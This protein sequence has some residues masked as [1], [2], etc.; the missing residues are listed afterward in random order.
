[1][2]RFENMAAFNYLWIIPVI[3]I[4]GYF[5]DRRSRKR[6]EAAIGSRLYPFLSSSVSQKK[7]TIKTV[8]QML[9]VFFFVLA[10]ARP[11]FGQ[12]KQEVKSE[13]VEIIFAVDVSES[14]MSED[15]KPN[16]LTQ[17]K[18]EL[19]RLV[20]LMPGNKIG[21]MAFAG[22]AA[23]L[24]PL[25]NDPAAIKMYIDAL[26][27]N[28]V[29]TQGTNFTDALNTAKEAFE[30]GGVSTDDT[31]KVT[32]VILIASDGEDHEPGAVDAAKKLAEDGTRIFT[33]AYG[34]EKGGAIPV[35]DGMGFLKGYKK[36]R[37]GQ[38]VI[39]TVKG[40]AL[41]AM[42]EAG[43]GSFYFATVGGDQVRHL[44][45]DINH[46]EK[47]QFDT[48][49]ATQYEE[50]FQILLLIGIIIATFELFIGERRRGFRFWKGRFEVPAE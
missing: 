40:D 31:V 11:Q 15:V 18:T 34:T 33:V 24:S 4:V 21:I 14:M 49:M 42:A 47:T 7:R 9:A 46:L 39:T 48:T 43:K 41:R 38:T 5:F 10:L 45:E 8:L 29:S 32:R 1:M 27:T 23:L 25:T 17:A 13:G 36:D 35:R 12:S 2:F 50:R 37:G 44:L 20:D 22:S 3:I 28:S 30:R 26:D 6:M 19:N 16:R